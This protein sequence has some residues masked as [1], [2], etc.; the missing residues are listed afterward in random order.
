M[1]RK[2]HEQC[3]A[4]T[5]RGAPCRCKILPGRTRCKF[6]GGLSTGPRTAAGKAQSTKNLEKARAVLA[7]KS[8]EWRSAVSR[9][10]AQTRKKKRE[11][12]IAQEEYQ[13]AFG[14][15]PAEEC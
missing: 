4:R 15:L 10:A 5:R 6:H 2:L 7:R 3:H 8:P 12:R 9:K 14:R 11:M 13:A 1:T